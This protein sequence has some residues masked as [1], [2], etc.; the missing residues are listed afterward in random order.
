MRL[1]EQGKFQEAADAFDALAQGAEERG[2]ILRAGNLWAQAARCYLK[3]DDV[4]EVYTRG[5][6]A[7]GLFKQAER[8]GAGRRKGKRSP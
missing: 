5:M 4:D 3:L 8:P 7:L 1:F 6:K 2:R